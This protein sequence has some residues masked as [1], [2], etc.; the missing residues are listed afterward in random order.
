MQGLLTH[1]G[2]PMQCY[3]WGEVNWVCSGGAKGAGGHRAP[4]GALARRDGAPSTPR[5]PPPRGWCWWKKKIGGRSKKKVV[6][7]FT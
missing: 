5:T 3:I 6:K 4:P 2:V 7:K 1:I